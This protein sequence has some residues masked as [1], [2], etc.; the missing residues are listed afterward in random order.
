MKNVP[1]DKAGTCNDPLT[2]ALPTSRI[3][4]KESNASDYS[5]FPGAGK[6]QFG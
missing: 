6:V 5:R 3:S 1:A 4:L 2:D